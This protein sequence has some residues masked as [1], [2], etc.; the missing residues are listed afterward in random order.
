MFPIGVK[1]SLSHFIYQFS[2]RIGENMDFLKIF[3]FEMLG[4]KILPNKFIAN[5]SNTLTQ[6]AR[7]PACPPSRLARLTLKQVKESINTIR[8]QY[9]TSLASTLPNKYTLVKQF[10]SSAA[11]YRLSPSLSMPGHAVQNRA[12]ICTVIIKY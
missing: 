10:S 7:P 4:E 6:R 1:S 3:I 12:E 11:V 8:V 2:C 5:S 9:S